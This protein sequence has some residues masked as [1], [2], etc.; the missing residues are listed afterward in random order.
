MSETLTAPTQYMGIC[1]TCLA[2]KPF[3]SKRERDLWE[4]FH[5]HERG[6]E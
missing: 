2:V 5:P 4:K 1:Y 3:A 6:D